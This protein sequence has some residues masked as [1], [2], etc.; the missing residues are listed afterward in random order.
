MLLFKPLNIIVS[1]RLREPLIPHRRYIAVFLLSCVVADLTKTHWTTWKGHLVSALQGQLIFIN[2][3]WKLKQHKTPFSLAV[4]WVGERQKLGKVQIFICFL[5]EPTNHV[6]THPEPVQVVNSSS[7]VTQKETWSGLIK[8]LSQLNNQVDVE[9]GVYDEKTAA[10]SRFVG[11]REYE[12]PNDNVPDGALASQGYANIDTPVTVEAVIEGADQ[13]E[14]HRLEETLAAAIRTGNKTLD[15]DYF[16][17]SKRINIPCVR[18][19]G[20]LVRSGQPEAANMSC[21]YDSNVLPLNQVQTSLPVSTNS[22]EINLNDVFN[23][24]PQT[25][26]LP[27]LIDSP[28]VLNNTGTRLNSRYKR[29][30]DLT[31]SWGDKFRQQLWEDRAINSKLFTWMTNPHAK[32]H[33]SPNHDNSGYYIGDNRSRNLFWLNHEVERMVASILFQF[34]NLPMRIPVGLRL[35]KIK[36]MIK[37]YQP[38][39]YPE[40]E[41]TLKLSPQLEPMR[42]KVATSI[43]YLNN[44]LEILDPITRISNLTQ[45]QADHLQFRRMIVHE[46]HI[47]DLEEALTYYGVAFIQPPGLELF[48]STFLYVS[49]LHLDNSLRYIAIYSEVNYDEH[50][51]NKQLR[52]AYKRMLIDLHSHFFNLKDR[53]IKPGIKMGQKKYYTKYLR[54]LRVTSNYE[55]IPESEEKVI[56]K[57]ALNFQSYMLGLLALDETLCL[58]ADSCCEIR[59]QLNKAFGSN[60]VGR[61][62][63][64]IY[65][66]FTY[67]EVLAYPFIYSD[68]LFQDG[69]TQLLYGTQ[70]GADEEEEIALFD[71]AEESEEEELFEVVNPSETSNSTGLV[72]DTNDHHRMKRFSMFKIASRGWRRVK[73]MVNWKNKY[74][75]IESGYRT[76]YSKNRIKAARRKIKS[77]FGTSITGTKNGKLARTS[78]NPAA[79]GSSFSNWIVK[80]IKNHRRCKRSDTRMCNLPGPSGT[81]GASVGISM[82]PDVSMRTARFLDAK[83]RGGSAANLRHYSGEVTRSLEINRDVSR[84]QLRD[85]P[86]GDRTPMP[87]VDGLFTTIDRIPPPS[88]LRGRPFSTNIHDLTTNWSGEAMCSTIKQFPRSDW[89]EAKR[90]ASGTSIDSFGSVLNSEDIWAKKRYKFEAKRIRDRSFKNR[91]GTNAQDR[92][93]RRVDS[94][95]IP[96]RARYQ[97]KSEI[98]PSNYERHILTAKKR[99]LKYKTTFKEDIAISD[100]FRPKSDYVFYKGT[101]KEVPR[102]TGTKH[103]KRPGSNNSQSSSGVTGSDAMDTS[104]TPKSNS[105]RQSPTRSDANVDNLEESFKKMDINNDMDIDSTSVKSRPSSPKGE[106]PMDTDP[107]PV[108]SRSQPIGSKIHSSDTSMDVDPHNVPP[109]PSDSRSPS[110]QTLN[111]DAS[112]HDNGLNLG[113]FNQARG[114]QGSA[115]QQ[116]GSTFRAQSGYSRPVQPSNSNQMGT[117]VGSP[118]VKRSE[119]LSRSV[120]TQNVNSAGKQGSLGET[121]LANQKATSLPNDLNKVSRADETGPSSID[122]L[123]PARTPSQ[124][125]LSTGSSRSGGKIPPTPASRRSKTGGNSSPTPPTPAPRKRPTN[126]EVDLPLNSQDVET[127]IKYTPLQ[128]FKKVAKNT[129]V[130]GGGS[131]FST[132]MAVEMG[133]SMHSQATNMGLEKSSYELQKETFEHTKKMDERRLALDQEQHYQ[134]TVTNLLAMLTQ[135]GTQ[136]VDEA[137]KMVVKFANAAG[138]KLKNGT[139][140]YYEQ[141]RQAFKESLASEIALAKSSGSPQ[142]VIYARMAGILKIIDLMANTP[143]EYK[144]RLRQDLQPLLTTVHAELLDQPNFGSLDY[145]KNGT[146]E[147]ELVKFKD[148]EA[149]FDYLD[150]FEEIFIEGVSTADGSF[151]EQDFNRLFNLAFQTADDFSDDSFFEYKKANYKINKEKIKTTLRAIYD[152]INIDTLKKLRDKINSVVKEVHEMLTENFPGFEPD[153]NIFRNQLHEDCLHLSRQ[154]I[155]KVSTM[156][157]HTVSDKL[158][159]FLE[160]MDFTI[161]ERGSKQYERRLVISIKILLKER[162]IWQNPVNPEVETTPKS[163]FS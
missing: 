31:I 55:L 27:Q 38:S 43:A 154:C 35:E 141:L 78:K 91:Q 137:T 90:A 152:D 72:D 122:S 94:R 56:L 42:N 45:P 153:L 120:S 157:T 63:C 57:K 101:V 46:E 155:R 7:L 118:F 71:E 64:E 160:H 15:D 96:K 62:V 19:R 100:P 3:I 6:E 8:S 97:Y 146:V 20:H 66:K 89:M 28:Y 21:L 98:S 114:H 87:N 79:S 14:R 65:N 40:G 22:S 53:V 18:T 105:R 126:N 58:I 125:T 32:T 16:V 5:A 61:K 103:K 115:M 145:E 148:E 116:S 158:K 128:R 34:G 10:L 30:N 12:E 112:W 156:A 144:E 41:Y 48:N 24:N 25:L 2:N 129:A 163:L 124:E 69:C 84:H 67:N 151:L 123:R 50:E 135:N 142:A 138:F 74:P 102:S 109:F 86:R 111:P 133:M 59:A 150:Q 92:W 37:E 82:T 44:R 47:I 143:D 119:Q 106:S 132:M 99:P 23:A 77:W 33:L 83:V 159:A 131:L 108:R 161:L 139:S 39:S 107:P 36:N 130:Y 121:N 29:D 136:G 88:E 149:W 73:V 4:L 110:I 93:N 60:R 85:I 162:N 80:N 76:N 113:N 51:Y 104:G 95:K 81:S 9:G 17:D 49:T 117:S 1:R 26:P 147:Y 75:K 70:D 11:S 52:E 140:L 134:T 127:F 54:K 68:P 13:K